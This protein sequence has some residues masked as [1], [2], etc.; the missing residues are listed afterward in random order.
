MQPVPNN[1]QVCAKVH[2]EDE[3]PWLQGQERLWCAS[4]S[5]CPEN[6]TASS[7]EHTASATLLT[8]QLSRSGMNS[9]P[10][11]RLIFFWKATLS[12]QWWIFLYLVPGLFED[13]C[14]SCQAQISSGDLR[15]GAST[16]GLPF[17]DLC[18]AT[19]LISCSHNS[20]ADLYTLAYLKEWH[21]V[22]MSVESELRTPSFYPYLHCL[23][24][25]VA[26]EG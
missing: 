2:E 3:S 11:T 15:L 13:C 5:S 23:C 17:W 12:K 24:L 20:P 6:R 8:E 9:T 7:P 22:F 10:G 16:K 14:I 1:F 26:T 21:E 4:D 18:P 25:T 19:L